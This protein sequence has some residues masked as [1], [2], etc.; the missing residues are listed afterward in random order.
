MSKIL[1]CQHVPHE[2]LGTFHPL[3]KQKGFRIRYVNFGRHPHATPSIKDYEGLIILGGPMNVDEGEKY[4][5]LNH[6]LYMIEEAMK[7]DLPILGI[8]LGSQLIAKAL[9]ASVSANTNMEVGWKTIEV[10]EDGKNDPLFS[11]FQDQET[12]FEWH[13]D[14]YTLPS[15]ATWLAKSTSCPIQAFRFGKKTYGFQFHLEV[16]QGMIKKWLQD[17]M[18]QQFLSQSSD[19]ALALEIEKESKKRVDT[20]KALS[21]KT[22]SGFI[23]LFG[24]NQKKHRLSSR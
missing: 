10:T 17:P 3:L 16:D 11:C 1:V 2:I 7:L 5:F 18:H 21:E 24:L 4:P 13:Y 15:Q 12:I 20:L 22:F 19:Q 23:N 9:G 14:S 6:E 8:C